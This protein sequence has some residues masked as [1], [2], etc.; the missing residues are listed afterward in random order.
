MKN[1][2][3]LLLIQSRI[4]IALIIIAMVWLNVPSSPIHIT[5]LMIFGLL[6]DVFDGIIARKLNISS[7]KLRV[8]DSNVDQFFWI[9]IIS[10]IFYLNWNFV[11]EQWPWLVFVIGL[12]LLAYVISYIKFKKSIA[13]HS[14]AAKFWT[15]SLLVFLIDLTL[16]NSSGLPFWICIGLGILTRLEII[17]IIL[18]LKKWTTD[19]PSIILVSKINK[20]IPIKKN[21]LFNG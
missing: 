2:I 12:E 13:T 15:I 19:V 17:G 9:S 11:T 21:A 16:N 4:L 3:P 14:I 8:W 10:C 1:K 18:L 20:G 7:E 5:W 6:T